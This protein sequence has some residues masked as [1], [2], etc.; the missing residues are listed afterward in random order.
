M[1]KTFIVAL[2]FGFGFAM[3][4]G[5]NKPEADLP[6]QTTGTETD[7]PR[8]NSSNPMRQRQ[9]GRPSAG[10]LPPGMTS[11]PPNAPPGVQQQ[12]QRMNGGLGNR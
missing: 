9:M 12:M 5:C 7:S 2:V 10:G 3:A 1:K 8:S 11:A 4:S 6:P